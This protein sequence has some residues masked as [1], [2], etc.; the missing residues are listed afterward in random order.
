MPGA[1]GEGGGEVP[2]STHS[3]IATRKRLTSSVE[4]TG[5][6]R[7]VPRPQLFPGQ[8][9]PVSGGA[10]SIWPLPPP[11]VELGR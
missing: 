10:S 7:N 6:A 2:S 3:R 9:T 4:G 8:F 1:R 5:F 11:C